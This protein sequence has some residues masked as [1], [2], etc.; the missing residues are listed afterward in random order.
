MI[1]YY[2]DQPSEEAAKKKKNKLL[3]G[4]MYVAIVCAQSSLA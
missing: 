2:R 4:L 1:H 3:K